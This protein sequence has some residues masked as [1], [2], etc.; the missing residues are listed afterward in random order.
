M[1]ELVLSPCLISV[2][3]G[4]WKFGNERDG[5]HYRAICWLGILSNPNKTLEPTA[6]RHDGSENGMLLLIV[7]FEWTIVL[8][9]FWKL[10][11]KKGDARQ[12]GHTKKNEKWY[13]NFF[14]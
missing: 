1:K 7:P 6:R 8:G 4:N 2:I 5:G 11:K 9:G 12:F 14:F 10:K 13:L 3:R